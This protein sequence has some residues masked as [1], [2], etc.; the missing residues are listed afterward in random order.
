M[1][2][3]YFEVTALKSLK[4]GNVT[5]FKLCG[6]LSNGFQVNEFYCIL[7]PADGRTVQYI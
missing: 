3:P 4:L 7:F 1:K 2:L 5:C 6:I